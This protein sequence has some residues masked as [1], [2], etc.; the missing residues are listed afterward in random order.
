M[1][2]E[3]IEGFIEEQAFLGSY[4]SAPCPPPATPPYP[5][6]KLS[7]FGVRPAYC[8]EMGGG[9]R[10]AKSQ[11]IRLGE[12]LALYK[13][14]NIHWVWLSQRKQRIMKRV[15]RKIP[16]FGKNSPT[17]KKFAKR[18]CREQFRNCVQIF[19]EIV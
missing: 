9:G 11:I 19:R 18:N 17:L 8:Q 14:F 12:T 6:S 4:D 5:V 1:W 13:S 3:S 16:F 15:E 10:G 2:P 7:L